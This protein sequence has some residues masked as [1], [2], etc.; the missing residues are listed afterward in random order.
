MKGLKTKTK[1]KRAKLQ[2]SQITNILK[3]LTRE[4][5]VQIKY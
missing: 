5:S 3:V 4:E 1:N 2:L